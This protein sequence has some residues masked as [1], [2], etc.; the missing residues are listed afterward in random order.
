MYLHHVNTN[1][2]IKFIDNYHF[3]FAELA[4]YVA[5]YQSPEK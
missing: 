3:Y 5:L 1:I 2:C 4:T